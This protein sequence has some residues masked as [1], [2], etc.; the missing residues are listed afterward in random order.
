MA[1]ALS[2]EYL[3]MKLSVQDIDVENLDYFR[4]LGEHRFSLQACDSCGLV[5]YPPTTACPW[6]A[7]DGWTWREVE[8]RGTIYSYGE[9]AHALQPAFRDHLPYQLLLVELDE[10]RGQPTEYEGLRIVGNLVEPDGT[11]ARAET[12]ARAGIG[13]RVR[14]VYVDVGEGFAIP[15][16]A[17][18][19]SAEQP[20]PWRYAED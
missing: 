4:A 19:D 10:Q 13:T 9:I 20:A 5:R 6:C 14:M 16:W 15:Q 3:G 2:G 8:P 1:D 17:I 12:V 11:L 7:S 18:D